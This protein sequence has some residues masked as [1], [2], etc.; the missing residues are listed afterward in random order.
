MTTEDSSLDSANGKAG[1]MTSAER[2]RLALIRAGLRLF[3]EQGFD[4]TSTRAL[5]A[6]AGANIG[7][8]AYH[9]GGKEGLRAACAQYIVETLSDVAGRALGGAAQLENPA[10]VTPA[11]AR[12]LL[13]QAMQAMV[14][15]IVSRPEA[16]EIV[17][18]ILRELTRP[19]PALDTVYSGVFEPVHS[20]FCALWEAATGEP[21]DSERAK[22][23]VFT[24]IGQVVYFRIAREPVK[25]RMGW[26]E[27]GPQEAAAV[28]E[29]AMSNLNAILD[30]RSRKS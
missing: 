13:T 14:G 6:E 25:R 5:A 10:G 15:F 16:G 8:I 12:A 21:A 29:V 11:E 20:R 18:F 19:T 30:A 3:A 26:S 4:A 27:I 9:F 1:R 22:I 7:S 28:I 23:T 2:T 24:V 17:Q